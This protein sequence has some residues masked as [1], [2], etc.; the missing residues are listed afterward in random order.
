MK[1]K[2][3]I[4]LHVVT[5]NKVKRE[6]F[7]KRKQLKCLILDYHRHHRFR[8]KNI[9]PF[10]DI[11]FRIPTQHIETENIETEREIAT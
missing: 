10:H 5:Q 6:N 1:V 4:S 9:V 7:L 2:R 3:E 8:F 11:H